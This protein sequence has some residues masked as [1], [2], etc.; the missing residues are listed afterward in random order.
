[1][2]NLFRRRSVGELRSM[3]DL[4]QKQTSRGAMTVSPLPLKAD[5]RSAVE[6]VRFGPKAD[7]IGTANSKFC[8]FA[9]SLFGTAF[10]QPARS[11]VIAGFCRAIG[12]HAAVRFVGKL[13]VTR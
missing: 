11:S 8:G 12:Q 10:I 9:A 13:H 7:I 4:G 1:M 3:S 2:A 6:H 5:V